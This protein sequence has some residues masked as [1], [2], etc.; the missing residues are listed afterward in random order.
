LR[1]HHRRLIVA[2][3]YEK[4][5]R[6]ALFT[7]NIPE[8]RNAMNV[9]AM[10]ELHEA[11]V[12]FRDDEELWVG[13]V[14]GS[15]EKAFCSGAD[16]SEMLPFIKANRGKPEAIPKT[17][18]RGLELFKP[19]IAAING[20]ALGGGL[21][22]ALA[23]DLR[24]AAETA[25]LGTPEVTLGLIPGWGATQRLPRS[26]PWSKAAEILFLGRPIDAEEAYRIGLVNRVVPQ[27]RVMPTAREWAEAL[28]HVGPLGVRA[29]K[30]AMLRGYSMSLDEGL[31]LEDSLFAYLLGTEDYEEGA[32]AFSEKRKADFKAK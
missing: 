10:R 17:P 2:I 26:I 29:A 20:V 18:M 11:M 8:T 21:E 9:Q 15:G 13:I 6:I 3:D 25:R 24:V 28:C 1:N 32:A 19:L 14:T 23:C 12:D 4:E 5:R 27:D 30:Q 7:I 16:I 22:I 31:Q